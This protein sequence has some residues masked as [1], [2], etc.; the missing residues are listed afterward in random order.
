[1]RDLLA[2]WK[3]WTQGEK[4]AVIAAAILIVLAGPTAALIVGA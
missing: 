2:D 3:R 1:M 4:I